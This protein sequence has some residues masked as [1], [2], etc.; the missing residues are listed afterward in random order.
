MST[1]ANTH[2]KE[3]VKVIPIRAP[4]STLLNVDKKEKTFNGIEIFSKTDKNIMKEKFNSL[5]E[6][7]DTYLNESVSSNTLTEKDR[8]TLLSKAT[9]DQFSRV[10]EGTNAFQV[11]LKEFFGDKKYR[12]VSSMQSLYMHH[13]MQYNIVDF[14]KQENYHL[15]HL[16]RFD[17]NFESDPIM[18]KVAS[19]RKEKF[20]V[21]NCAV[22]FLINP[23][24]KSRICISIDLDFYRKI[25]S[26]SI[27]YVESDQKAYDFLERW[28]T[29][30]EKNNFYKGQAIDA[31]CGFLDLEDVTWDDV[32]LTDKVRDQLKNNVENIFEFSHILTKNNIKLKRGLIL[33]GSPGC[34][35]KGTKI[36]I[37]KKNNKGKHTIICDHD[38]IDIGLSGIDKM[39]IGEEKEVDIQDFFEIVKDGGTYE[40]ATPQGW[41]EVGDLFLNKDRECYLLRT[42]NGK[43]LGGS[44][45]HKV[46]THNGWKKLKDIDV[47]KDE[48]FTI[49]G[50]EPVVSKE[51]LGIDNTYDLQVLHKEHKYYTNGIVSHNCGKTMVCKALS[52][53]L[54]CT[55]LYVLPSH[56]DNI[57]DIERICDMASSLSPTLMIL[58][59]VDGIACDRDEMHNALVIELMNQL[60]GLEKFE[61]VITLATTNLPDK[62]EKAI[63]NRP[64]RFDRVIQLPKPDEDCCLRMLKIFT[65]DFI[66]NKKEVD[67]N[68]L[69]KT[70]CE[71]DQMSGAYIR[72]LC[73]TA[74]TMAIYNGDMNKNQKPILNKEHFKNALEEIRD[75]ELTQLKEG[76][77][78]QYGFSDREEETEW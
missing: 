74:A 4:L 15:V 9:L 49:D 30:A 10:F 26:Y 38:M 72:E 63:K 39:H 17:D 75:K 12:E 36:K 1:K 68:I 77:K 19:N 62:V 29:F 3:Y 56:I 35:I 28:I 8:Q 51:Y 70:L 42:E 11:K 47:H 20:E 65:K 46:E 60:D 7:K 14:L 13:I 57:S 52:K 58:E 32:V 41:I 24:N 45:S 54:N 2:A 67:F 64:G 53:E 34:V 40:I 6:S 50:I 66:V 27:N 18:G 73:F 44:D 48:V 43:E 16:T 33:A 37:R 69:S 31:N 76:I 21:F 22:L 71:K 78:S 55:I 61:N 59:D 5:Y 25:C 23:K